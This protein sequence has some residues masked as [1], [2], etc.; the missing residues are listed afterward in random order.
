MTPQAGVG[1]TCDAPTGFQSSTSTRPSITCRTDTDLPVGEAFWVEV[2]VKSESARSLNNIA[3]PINSFA[4]SDSNNLNNQD[5]VQLPALPQS[6]IGVTK[7]FAVYR[8]TV[9]LAPV[10]KGGP[11]PATGTGRWTIPVK[12]AAWSPKRP[13]LSPTRCRQDSP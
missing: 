8:P 12:C 1:W 3:S 7:S 13:S 2:T 11:I 10:S 5:G 6:D 4:F 9:G